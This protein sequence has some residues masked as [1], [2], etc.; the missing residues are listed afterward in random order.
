MYVVAVFFMKKIG[1][2]LEAYRMVFVEKVEFDGGF[3][4][5]KNI[6][7]TERS[8]TQIFTKKE[9]KTNFMMFC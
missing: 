3:F 4:L 6:V 2:A 5:Y 1:I 9:D 7:Q 8:K